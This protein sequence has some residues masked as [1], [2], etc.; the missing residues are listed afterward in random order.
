VQTAKHARVDVLEAM[1]ARPDIKPES[2]GRDEGFQ[3]IM[4]CLARIS[5][6]YLDRSKRNGASIPVASD[7][8]AK[9]LGEVIQI[10]DFGPCA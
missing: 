2:I 7:V 10:P 1:C 6:K 5:R 8:H 9:E 3:S 4:P